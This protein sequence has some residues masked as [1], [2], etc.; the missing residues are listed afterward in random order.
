MKIKLLKILV[1]T[2]I[3]VLAGLSCKKETLNN[4]CKSRF[5]YYSKD[6]AVPETIMMTEIP[7][8]G[9]IS[10]Y[11]TLSSDIINQ[12]LNTYPEIK[13]LSSSSNG[14]WIKIGINCQSCPE[15][16]LL[17]SQIKE[18]PRVSNCNKGLVDQEG[19]CLGI[20]DRFICVL[21]KETSWDKVNELIISTNTTIIEYSGN[22]R[23]L[24][25]KADKNSKGDALDIAN[26]FYESGYFVYAEPEFISTFYNK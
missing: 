5:R 25:L 7:N 1:I 4:D 10:F 23:T 17:L 21:K 24:L 2:Y 14:N 19:N 15:T 26:E 18:D 6:R 13:L 16:E 20:L 9:T 12:I 3:I 8:E 11:D 22:T